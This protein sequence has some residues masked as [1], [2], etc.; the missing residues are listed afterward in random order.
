MIATSMLAP[1]VSNDDTEP[2]VAN[3]LEVLTFS[4]TTVC[5]ASGKL[6]P[7]SPRR[8]EGSVFMGFGTEVSGFWIRIS[9]G[10]FIQMGKH[11]RMRWF[12]S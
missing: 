7:T 4:R 3:S 2:D 5:A 9:T 12:L 8:I 10:E 1:D 6:R 11:Y